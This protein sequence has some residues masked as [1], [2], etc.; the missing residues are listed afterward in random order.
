MAITF[1]PNGTVTGISVGGLPDGIVD[2]D[3]LANSAVSPAKRGTASILQIVQNI[4]H[5]RF[6]TT[7]G[8]FVAS[9]L[10][11]TITP[12]KAGSKILI[13][14]PTLVNSNGTNHRIFADVYRSVDGATATGI[15]P[16]GTNHTTGGNASAGFFGSIRGDNS[17]IQVPMNLQFL[18][19]PSYTLG[20]SIVYTLYVRSGTGGTVEVPGSNEQEPGISMATEIAA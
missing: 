19:T 10:A 3:M 6:A 9:N 18:D 8:T 13:N 4:T 11:V 1:N 16:Q 7:S 2:T 20:N 5:T 12:L 17:R 14:F 15:A